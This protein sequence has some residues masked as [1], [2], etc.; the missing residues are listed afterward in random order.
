MLAGQGLEMVAI[1]DGIFVAHAEEERELFRARTRQI[2]GRHGSKRRNTSAGG[3][4]ERFLGWIA[5]G[6]ESERRGHFD[7]ITW[8]HR[9]K[10]GAENA[11]MHQVETQ[12][13]AIAVWER[14][15]GIRARNLLSVECFLERN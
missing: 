3:D 6:E 10:I 13:K 14:R 5:N 2:V 4:E 1:V 15:N 8:L 9:E 7:G 12:L 11:L